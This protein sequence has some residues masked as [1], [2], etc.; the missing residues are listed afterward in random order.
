MHYEVNTET[1][2]VE[3]FTEGN[4]VPFIHQPFNPNGEAWTSA[5]ES[6]AWA[7]AVI[8]HHAN[9]ELNEFPA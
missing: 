2:T 1:F 5:E 9:P 4:E 3:I 6:S 7:E 8:A